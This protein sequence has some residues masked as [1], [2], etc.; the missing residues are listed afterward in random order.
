M[1]ASKSLRCGNRNY[2]VA[3]RL[4]HYESLRTYIR[5]CTIKTCRYRIYVSF[6]ST[7]DRAW[8]GSL[9]VHNHNIQAGVLFINQTPSAYP[10]S[11]NHYCASNSPPTPSTTTTFDRL[12]LLFQAIDPCTSYQQPNF[13]QTSILHFF[14]IVSLLL[15][16]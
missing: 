9:D 3:Y 2:C 11:P 6:V 8:N 12:S 5:T 14:R 4:R 13:L 1:L 15:S 7:L 16:I 10:I